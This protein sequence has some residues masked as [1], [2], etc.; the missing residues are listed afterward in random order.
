MSWFKRRRL[1]RLLKIQIRLIEIY[2]E[3]G[4]FDNELRSMEHNI[5]IEIDRLRKD[6]RY[7]GHDV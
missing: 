1:K 4:C 6:L 7:R 5:K 3:T 2:R